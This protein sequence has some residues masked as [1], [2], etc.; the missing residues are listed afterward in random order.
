MRAAHSCVIVVVAT[1][2]RHCVAQTTGTCNGICS[3]DEEMLNASTDVKIGDK[4][5]TCGWFDAEAKE[6]NNPGDC[7]NSAEAAATAGCTCG[8]PIECPGICA[9]G[10]T[11]NT[12]GGEFEVCGQRATCDFYDIQ[13]QDVIDGDICSQNAMNA[14]LAGCNCTGE[15]PNDDEIDCMGISGAGLASN[16]VLSI[17]LVVSLLF[18]SALFE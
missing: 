12:L 5:A 15:Y 6:L 9:E 16:T 10:E 14:R 2:A 11:L 17:L 1:F 13:N 8:I 7:T 18:V 3:E 4:Y